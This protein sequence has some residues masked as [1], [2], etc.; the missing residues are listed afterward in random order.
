MTDRCWHLHYMNM[1]WHILIWM[2]Y[3]RY[4]LIILNR[5]MMI[6]CHFTQNLCQITWLRH[7]CTGQNPCISVFFWGNIQSP[8]VPTIWVW[9]AGYKSLWTILPQ[10]TP[11]I[12]EFASHVWL[13]EGKTYMPHAFIATCLSQMPN[14]PP[15]N[16]L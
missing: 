3:S 14:S 8:Q 5:D 10:E 7:L 1:Y 15:D 16:G 4:N 2:R 13:L 6:Y 11:W 12:M 9:I